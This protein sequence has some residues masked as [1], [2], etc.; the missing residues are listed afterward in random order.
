VLDWIEALI[1]GA[2]AGFLVRLAT[3]WLLSER[4]T[5]PLL[6][7]P[8]IEAV[9]AALFALVFAGGRS[10]I[11]PAQLCGYAF[12][13]VLLAVT[14]TDVRAKLIPDRITG[15]GVVLG[16]VCAS[17]SGLPLALLH[18]R[19]LAAWMGLTDSSLGLGLAGAA[20][21][22]LALE[23]LRRLLGRAVSMEVMGMGD[24]KLLAVAGAF[25]GPEAVLLALVPGVL[26]GVVFGVGWT[27]VARTPHF[28]FGPS[29]G[30]GA[31]LTMLFAGDFTAGIGAFTDWMRGLS[32]GALWIFQGVLLVIAIALLIR[33]R[34]RAA[35]YTKAIE[36]DYAK[37][38]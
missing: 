13:I 37:R 2:A 3:P 20:T 7:V 26:C 17:F 25:L 32:R 19:D 23:V 28:P 29:L 18:Q 34:R 24:S 12:A 22:F 31:L 1:A 36:D 6:G 4:P 9:G 8:W 5:R 16:L 21:G 30:L 35:R 27:V 11:D 33:V 15:P 38:E 14:A 10:G